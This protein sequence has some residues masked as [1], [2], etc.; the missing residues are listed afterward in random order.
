MIY[1][2]SMAILLACLAHSTI[3]ISNF[4]T[5]IATMIRVKQSVRRPYLV[6]DPSHSDGDLRLVQAV[7][8][9][10][11]LGAMLVV[12]TLPSPKHLR[13]LQRFRSSPS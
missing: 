1:I 5:I 13:F 10:G 4:Y 11:T 6:V 9:C 3:Q 12:S 2:L 8:A 7:L